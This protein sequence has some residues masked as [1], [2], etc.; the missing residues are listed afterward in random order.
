[1][2]KRIVKLFESN[3]QLYLWVMAVFSLVTM[4]ASLPMGILGL[5]A[6]LGLY[7]WF[8][9]SAH[10]QRERIQKHLDKVTDEM[11]T[12]GKASILTA[13]FAMMVFRPDTQEVLWSNDSFLQ[14]TG[15]KEDLFNNKI[16]ELLP[17]FSAQW[18]LE[19]KSECPE[20]FEF[21]GRRFRVFGNL[22][23]PGGK[24]SSSQG[25]LATTYWMDTTETD[26]LR[27]RARKMLPSS[28]F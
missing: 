21:G 22:T 12:A 7:I 24:G 17:G 28:P 8:R 4:T 25:F 26:A 14:I 6:T 11:E 16:G 20:P 9:Q 23:H 18:L 5:L 27:K 10:K 2:S 13:P 19:G 3:M 1:M 15:I